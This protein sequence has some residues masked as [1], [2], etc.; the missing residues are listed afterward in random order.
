MTVDGASFDSVYLS[1]HLDDAAL[2]CGGRIHQ[3]TRSG[4]CVAV[5]T[6]FA[7]DLD[8]DPSNR[9]LREVYDR[10]ALRPSEAM[11]IRRRE[12]IEAC[13][14]LGAEAVHWDFPEA[15][16]RHPD[17]ESL[18]AL[19]EDAPA[20]DDALVQDL[21]ERLAELGD[22]VE[23]VAPL[24]L[25]GHIDHR[26]VR[27]AASK[28][29]GG[30]VRFYED[31]PY[32]LKFE[33]LAGR[34]EIEGLA[35]DVSTLGAEDIVARIEAIETYKSQIRAL[36]GPRLK[37]LVPGRSVASRV[38]RYVDRVGGERLWSRGALHR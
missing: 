25:G 35:A 19:F 28:A 24:G 21:A 33:E 17:L 32:A 26:V 7:G 1:P 29:F 27:R 16:G 8:D 9:V 37:R 4:Q 34:P 11:A 38:R 5:V 23:I 2:S 36:F 6:I 3:Q 31:F 14:R 22:D 10:M 12:D 20:S 15:L 13:L 18:A 30:R